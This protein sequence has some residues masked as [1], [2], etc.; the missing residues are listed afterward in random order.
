VDKLKLFATADKAVQKNQPDKAL[1]SLEKILSADPNDV[2]ALNK[3]ADICLKV[4]NSEKAL[5]YLTRV[6]GIYT[7]DGFYS[8][9]IAIYKRILKIDESAPKDQTIRTHERLA[10][11]YGQLG[12]VSDAMS[13]F[14]IVVDFFDQAND[15]EALL[16]VLKKISDLDPSNIESQVKLAEIFAA[17]GK[18]EDAK[19]TFRSL[20]EGFEARS[21][22]A[23]VV[24]IYE[25]WVKAFP[26]EM[27]PL[28]K[29][30]GTYLR[31]GEPKK[32]LAKLQLAFREDPHNPQVLEMLSQSFRDLKQPEK[33]KAVDVELLKIYRKA[34]LAEKVQELE[35][36]IKGT[37]P[38][39]RDAIPI[40]SATGSTRA[41]SGAS[42]LNEE[43]LDP[44]E[45]LIKQSVQDPD[46]R[47]IISECDVYL[48]YGLAE[49]AQEVL[50]ANLQ[51]FPKSLALRWKLKTVLQDLQEKDDVIHALSEIILLAK[52][53]KLNQ[54]VD[55]AAEDLFQIDPDHSALSGLGLSSKK[56]PTA[57]SPKADEEMILDLQD[58]GLSASFDESDIS[59]VVDDDIISDV[60][61]QPKGIV[62]DLES[63]PLLESVEE[64]SDVLDLGEPEVLLEASEAE[65]EAQAS[66]QE[67]DLL[68]TPEDEAGSSGD[69]DFLL[70]EAD[71]SDDELR[72]L[73]SQLDPAPVGL[74]QEPALELEPLEIEDEADKELD[75]AQEAMAKGL[76]ISDESGEV[77]GDAEFEVKQGLEEVAFF[78][79]Q[80]LDDEAESLLMSLKQKYPNYKNW[81]QK[82]TSPLLEA[83]DRPASSSPVTGAGKEVELEALGTKMK[84]KVQED[85]RSD[86]D[87]GFF[88]L[89]AEILAELE[90]EENVKSD[91]PVEVQGVFDAFKKGV[92]ASVSDADV[93]THYD[94]GI[95]YREMGLVDDAIKEFEL[96][97]KVASHQTSALYQIGLCEMN[98]GQLEAAKKTF[99]SALA[100]SSLEDQEKISI[101]YE[102]A[103]CLF[104]LN[105][106]SEAV[107][108]Y[109]EVLALDPEFREAQT[110]LQECK[111]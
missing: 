85:E 99:E 98:Q 5:D 63:E 83:M 15:R 73:G 89:G 41:Q 87:S 74:D 33:S 81:D 17:E 76:S 3:A 70:T 59:I 88:D 106:R 19:D 37:A 103:E 71:F 7:R 13:H 105:Q 62:E 46:E 68:E 2:K 111:A 93:E 28:E 55:V 52:D 24:A 50:N 82:I 64:N 1:E 86:D 78:R 35:A 38:G 47:K 110:R 79:S 30:V 20:A 34:S 49:K 6:G 23:D 61:E 11:L 94:L 84:L 16:S 91:V 43:S 92:A 104:Q 40:A 22:L 67:L 97:S 12:L 80:K 32:A 48:K 26:K 72:K 77:V 60:Q 109:E 36:R 65:P 100:G 4:N 45:T 42:K 69:A 102:L 96:C 31:G 54:W 57:P 51:K 44:A 75:K 53:L 21:Q 14:K 29:L 107:K 56:N 66:H 95:A 108:F 9:A 25:R 10:S 101:S 8:K 27:E 18:V 58:D 90:D 39:P